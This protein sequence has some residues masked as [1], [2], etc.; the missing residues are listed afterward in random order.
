MASPEE[1]L[2]N[3][4]SSLG[5]VG[6]VLTLYLIFVLDA[7]LFPALPPLFIVIFYTAYAPV[8]GP[9]PWGITLVSVAVAGEVSGNLLLYLVVRRFLVDPSRMPKRIERLMAGW[10]HFLVVSDERVI[11]LN[12][13]APV[14]PLV[15]AFIAVMR[16]DLR[17]SL[18]YVALGAAG[19]YAV[20]VAL[21]GLLGVVLSRT[22]ATVAAIVLVTLIVGISFAAAQLRRRRILRSPLTAGQDGPEAADPSGP[23]RP[24]RTG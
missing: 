20:V 3:L 2:A 8:I 6:A 15:G 4:F 10:V 18:A 13:I 7:T 11:L 24:P 12:R 21:V 17:R 9:V 14:V 23:P 5:P 16:W 19:Y 1:F 22:E